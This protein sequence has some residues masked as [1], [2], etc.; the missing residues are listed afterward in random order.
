M[1]I[2][3]AAREA[4][5]KMDVASI[6][7]RISFVRGRPRVTFLPEF[8]ASSHLSRILL[9]IMET[10]SGIRAVANIKLDPDVEA[11]MGRTGLKVVTYDRGGGELFEFAKGAGGSDVILD[12]GDFGIE[13]CTY[14]LGHNAVDVVKKVIEIMGEYNNGKRT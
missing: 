5:T 10:E 3:Q 1:N 4:S 9:A 13:P 2:A 7:G 11:A 8:G 14:V 12:H 6:P